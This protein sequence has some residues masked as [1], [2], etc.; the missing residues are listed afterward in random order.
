MRM[1]MNERLTVPKG[2]VLILAIL[3]CM[4]WTGSSL[5]AE[6]VQAQTDEP[7]P[8]DQAREEEP[9]Q[10][11]ILSPSEIKGTLDRPQAIYLIPK[12]SMDLGVVK[13]QKKFLEDLS[14]E[15]FPLAEEEKTLDLRIK[16]FA[17]SFRE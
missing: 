17:D 14:E 2:V 8:E 11:F 4:V 12:M 16:S 5:F 6:E 10:K 9:V 15:L 1:R 13:L 3:V 7:Q